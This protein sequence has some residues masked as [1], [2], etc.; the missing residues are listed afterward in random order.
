MCDVAE[1][2]YEM[3]YDDSKITIAASLLNLGKISIEDIAACTG[4]SVEE[5]RTLKKQS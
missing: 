3:G 4:L 2:I 1:G 5:V